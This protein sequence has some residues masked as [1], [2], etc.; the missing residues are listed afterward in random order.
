MAA[1][2][3]NT[4]AFCDVCEQ[5]EHCYLLSAAGDHGTVPRS[6]QLPSERLAA[7]LR[8]KIEA[9]DWQPGGQLPS[10]T[11]LSQTYSVSRATV[12]KALRT[13]VADGLVVTRHGWGTFVAEHTE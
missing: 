13:L 6:S 7:E 2:M 3:A 8:R 11:E 12:S 1:L 9:G 5:R 4:I 10:V